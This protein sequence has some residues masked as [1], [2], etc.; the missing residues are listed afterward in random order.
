M[1]ELA[2]LL[3]LLAAQETPPPPLEPPGE[4]SPRAP[5]NAAKDF[6][7]FAF[8]FYDQEDG[9]GNPNL[10][11]DMAVWEP[12][13][14]YSRSLSERWSGSLKVQGDVISAASVSKHKRFPAGTQSGASGDKYLGGELGAFYA[15]SDQTALGAGLSVSGEYDYNSYGGYL[16]WSCDTPDKNDTFVVR[17]SAYFD[18][19]DV[20]LFTGEGDG[21]DTRRSISLGL[22][23]T[24]VWGPRTAGTLNWDLTT[25]RGF[26]PTP[27]NSVVAAGTE[28]R[29]ILP[30]TRFR[31]AF[32]ARL[33]H[34]LLDDLAV[35][36]GLGFYFD[37]WGARAFNVE[38]ALWWEA[39]PE[40]VI[41]RPAY[42]F[43]SQTEVDDFLDETAAAIPE[44]RTQ[45]SDLADFDSHTFGLKLVFPRVFL[46]GMEQ[47][48]EVGFDYTLRSDDLDALSATF[49][50]QWRF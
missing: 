11:E 27:Y 48:V 34:L 26:L 25:Q 2:A 22:G 18:T 6:I 42:R 50:Y 13:I 44:E 29:E 37:D 3:S 46:F 24:R 20:I 35:E 21:T 40:A 45:D 28:V 4:V 17:L 41:V 38:L 36:P 8:N 5:A 1:R 47:E 33:R 39:V 16:K 9:G 10:K 30:D 14:L 12:Q 7:R 23:W 31:S 19:L 43:H 32:H 49:G 15:W